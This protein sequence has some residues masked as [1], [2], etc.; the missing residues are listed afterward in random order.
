[1]LRCTEPCIDPPLGA[2]SPAQ[3]LSAQLQ[4]RLPRVWHRQVPEDATSALS[5]SRWLLPL[6]DGV[7]EPPPILPYVHTCTEAL[8][9]QCQRVDESGVFG[10]R[11]MYFS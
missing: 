9:E 7:G 11:K 1:M 4:W 3:V 2:G 5:L 6:W 10:K 8:H